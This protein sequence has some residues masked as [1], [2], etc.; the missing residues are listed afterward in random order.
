MEFPLGGEAKFAHDAAGKRRLLLAG[1][2]KHRRK[3]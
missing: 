2:M 3:Q 1:A